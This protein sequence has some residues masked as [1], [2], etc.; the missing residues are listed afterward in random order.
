M[1]T[2]KGVV[3]YALRK[4]IIRW[5]Q[6]VCKE[7]ELTDRATLATVHLANVIGQCHTGQRR[8]V[9]DGAH[10]GCVFPLARDAG[11]KRLGYAATG[12]ILSRPDMACMT[13]HYLKLAIATLLACGF[14]EV[15]SKPITYRSTGPRGVRR[16]PILY[17]VGLRFFRILHERHRMQLTP[18]H[19]KMIQRQNLQK[20][21]ITSQGYRYTPDLVPDGLCSGYSLSGGCERVVRTQAVCVMESD[22]DRERREKREERDRRLREIETPALPPVRRAG[23][24]A[25][26]VVL[27]NL[28]EEQTARREGREPVRMQHDTRIDDGRQGYREAIKREK[29][30]ALRRSCVAMRQWLAPIEAEK[31][32]REARGGW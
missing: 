32:R 18:H 17:R 10:E 15:V 21:D 30:E 24:S 3:G 5:L 28:E 1:N 9:E 23:M 4:P 7:R 31:A 8:I 20:A 16:K 13:E 26:E 22:R 19:P 11:N 14:I 25:H 6:G 29:R 27:Y 12:G 2:Y